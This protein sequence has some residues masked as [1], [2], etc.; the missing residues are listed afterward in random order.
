MKQSGNYWKE[1]F[2]QLEEAQNNI[3]VSKTREIQ[4]QFEK[5][6]A[7]ING[8]I[9]AWYQRFAA[10][11]GISMAEA[12]RMLSAQELK[13]FQWNVE[14]YI[15]YGKEN[16]VSQAWEKQ[17]ENASARV[18]IS[19]LESLKLEVQQELER[20]YGNYL[21]SIDQHIKDLYTSGFYHSA[22]EI[23]KGVGIGS[24]FQRLDSDVVEKIISKPWAVDGKNFSD[25]I[26]ENK[27]KLINQV[28]NSLSVMCI[29]GEAPDRAIQEI[30]KNMNVSRSQAGRL[31]MTESAAFAGRAR[32][33]CMKSLGVEEF[34]VV[35]SL[36][37]ITCDYCQSM[38][39]KHFPMGDFQIGVTAPPFH[40]NC[41]GCTCP[42]F[43]DEFT[44]GEERAA[45]GEDGKV[46]YVPSDMTYEEWKKSFVDGNT[47][48]L[49][50]VSGNVIINTNNWT[51]L[52][53]QQSY[54]KQTAID[55]LQSKYGIQ[56]HDSKKYPMDDKLL[57]DCV[58]WLDSF[59]S[60]YNGFMQK[61]PCKIPVIDNKAPSKM[62]EAMGYY[63]YYT[64]NT[65]VVELALNGQYHSDLDAF[66][67]YVDQCVK[68]KRYPEN[69]TIHKTFVH[70][71]GH[72]VSN[73]M[74]WLTNNQ[75]WQHEF[76]QECINDFKKIEPNYIWNTHLKMG[77]YVSKYGATSESELFAEAFA[78]Y[79]GGENPRA[80]A[81]IFG[82]KLDTLLKGVK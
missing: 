1:R 67:K 50:N 27:T 41:R 55:R 21:D 12:R 32:A 10:N 29:T 31:V 57:A 26:W 71:F 3:S 40:P 6:Q 76:I 49:Q 30:A 54:T 78:E 11:N 17:L 25:R 20:M 77:D 7:A 5:A 68:S 9:D 70:E 52:N 45:R 51:G 33:D 14:D 35:E 60:Q 80:F 36:D 75:N 2:R 39:G 56:F 72:H 19:R 37:H 46:Y 44:I 18:H 38:D 43:D 74:R 47:E 28:H 59:N 24:S 16:A 8:K 48:G 63:S 42:Y 66:Q 82:K 69:A 73:S 62:K 58:G 53:Y 64:N 15:K 79:F 4:E 81:K 34:E 23:Q 61:N 22:Y 65:G 13:E